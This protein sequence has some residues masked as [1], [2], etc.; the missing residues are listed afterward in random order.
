MR[1]SRSV[2][3][4]NE[5]RY[6]GLESLTRLLDRFHLGIVGIFD[7]RIWLRAEPDAAHGSEA[8]QQ[9]SARLFKRSRRAGVGTELHPQ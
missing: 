9:C 3:A 7:S 6:R 2:C 1:P 5:T 8:F 4:L